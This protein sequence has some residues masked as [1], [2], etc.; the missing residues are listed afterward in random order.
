MPST[1]RILAAINASDLLDSVVTCFYTE[2]TTLISKDLQDGNSNVGITYPL[3]KAI[4][5]KTFVINIPTLKNSSG[6]NLTISKGE[7]IGIVGTIRKARC[8]I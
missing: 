7:S 5:L 2:M 4:K 1:N 6:I 3:F 8:Q